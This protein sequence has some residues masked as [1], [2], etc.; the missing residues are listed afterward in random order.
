MLEL[1]SGFLAFHFLLL[2]EIRIVAL[3][4]ASAMS[5]TISKISRMVSV[6][7]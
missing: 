2:F 4:I 3:K 5:S 7:E 1:G 6:I